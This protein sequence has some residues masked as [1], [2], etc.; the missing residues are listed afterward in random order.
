MQRRRPRKK[1]TRPPKHTIVQQAAEK[2]ENASSKHKVTLPVGG[3]QVS[4]GTFRH[5]LCTENEIYGGM[6]GS[7]TKCRGIH[8]VTRCVSHRSVFGI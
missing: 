2:E 1:V 8:H 7:S 5:S 6:E 3:Y 4:R